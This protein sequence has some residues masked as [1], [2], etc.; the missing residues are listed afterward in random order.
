M[1]WTDVFPSRF[2]HTTSECDKPE[3]LTGSGQDVHAVSMV[4]LHWWKRNRPF[5]HGGCI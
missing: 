2:T 5:A 1:K 3:G 4:F